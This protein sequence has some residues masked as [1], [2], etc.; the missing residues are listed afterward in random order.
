MPR[1]PV[2]P[3]AAARRI[4]DD[5]IWRRRRDRL[6]IPTTIRNP[7]VNPSNHRRGNDR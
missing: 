2:N 1:V 7:I 5:F 6:R 4:C 3:R